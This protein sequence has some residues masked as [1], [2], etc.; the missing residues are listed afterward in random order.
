MRPL[1]PFD[2]HVGTVFPFETRCRS[3]EVP[4]YPPPPDGNLLQRSR[5]G[6]TGAAGDTSPP[7]RSPI[8]DHRSPITD[9]DTD[10]DTD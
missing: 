8:T 2:E 10:T 5:A 9:T 7:A 3:T 1:A 6:D 4:K